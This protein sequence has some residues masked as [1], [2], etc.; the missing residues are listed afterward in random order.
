MAFL[1]KKEQVLE[2]VLTQH[3]RKM[4]G[5]GKLSPKYYA[6]SDDEINYQVSEFSQESV[7]VTTEPTGDG[8]FLEDGS[9]FLITESG[10]FIILE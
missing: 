1:D 5:K 4:L 8:L 3:G 10:N 9:T 6:F 7:D 2:I